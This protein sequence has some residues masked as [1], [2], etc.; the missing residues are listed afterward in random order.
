MRK[1]INPDSRGVDLLLCKERSEPIKPVLPRVY[2]CFVSGQ[3][4]AGE[5]AEKMKELGG[6]GSGSGTSRGTGDRSRSESGMSTVAD[7]ERPVKRMKL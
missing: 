7:E 4:L 3:E 5:K 6:S 2:R 1:I